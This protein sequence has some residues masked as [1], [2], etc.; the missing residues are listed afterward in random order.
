[1]IMTKK[2]RIDKAIF[3]LIS[4]LCFMR[5]NNDYKGP[6]FSFARIVIL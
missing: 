5:L 1:M 6:K 3:K 4:R 2:N